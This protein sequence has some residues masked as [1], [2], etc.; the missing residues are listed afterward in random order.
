MSKP[1][2]GKRAFVTGSS[3][4]LGEGIALRLAQ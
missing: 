4:L 3:A 2:A 1:L